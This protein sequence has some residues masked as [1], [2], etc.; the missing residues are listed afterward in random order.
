MEVQVEKIKRRILVVDRKFQ[1]NYLALNTVFL[2]VFAFIIGAT[3]YMSV[4]YS[5]V[6]EFST[7]S[8]QQDL[9][10]VSM[11]DRHAA[12]TP[13]PAIRAQAQML[14]E[15]HMETLNVILKRTQIKLIPVI[16]IMMVCI[17]FI[18]LIYSHRIAGPTYRF[19]KSLRAVIDGDLNA[20]FFLRKKDEFHEVAALLTEVISRFS[21]TIISVAA[22]AKA[23]KTAATHA[24][25]LEQVQKIEE[26]VS[27][28]R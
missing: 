24:E 15:R 14:S 1:F 3:V 6:R 12:L 21:S 25:V 19:K 16:A 18:S 7:V 28:Y 13:T 11:N 23:I 4:M 8:I 10:T 9:R 27:K 22:N 17:L 20:Q 26:A 2:L 5:I